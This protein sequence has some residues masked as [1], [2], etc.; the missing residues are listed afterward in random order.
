MS[1]LPERTK[2]GLYALRQL[3]FVAC[4]GIDHQLSG[5]RMSNTER[6]AVEALRQ[7]VRYLTALEPDVADWDLSRRAAERKAGRK[8]T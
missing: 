4:S 2:S 6:R 5:Q 1:G 8:E 3:C 7:A